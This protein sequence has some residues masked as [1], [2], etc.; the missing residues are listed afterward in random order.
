MPFPRLLQ[1]V[2][3]EAYLLL[4]GNT[5]AGYGDVKQRE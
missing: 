2:A 5:T 1:H 4:R 3:T